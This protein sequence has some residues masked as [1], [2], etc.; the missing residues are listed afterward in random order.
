[1][2]LRTTAAICR[3]EGRYEFASFRSSIHRRAP[4]VACRTVRRWPV[5]RA[6]ALR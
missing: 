2:D 3:I 1:M 6:L 4:V 5:A